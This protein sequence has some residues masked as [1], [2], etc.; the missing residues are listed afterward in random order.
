MC[1]YVAVVLV[2]NVKKH[3]FVYVLYLTLFKI[4]FCDGIGTSDDDD[5]DEKTKKVASPLFTL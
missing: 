1:V 5:D 4:I 2:L 3:I